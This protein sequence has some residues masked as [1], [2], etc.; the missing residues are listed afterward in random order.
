MKARVLALY[1]PQFHP[2]PENDLWWGKGFT[3]WTNVGKARRMF[4]GHYQPRVPADLGYYDLRVSETRQ[5]QADLALKHGVEGFLYWHYWFGHGKQLLEKPFNEVLSSGKPLFPFALAWANATWKGFAYGEM[6]RNVLI[7]QSYPGPGDQIM[8]FNTVLPAFKDRRYITVD[9]K[10]FFLVFQ[11]FELPDPKQFIELWQNLARTNGL[12]GIHFVAQ[13]DQVSKVDELR[14]MGFDAVNLIRM[15]HSFS[16]PKTFM[17]SS[18]L[19]MLGRI[20]GRSLNIRSYKRSLPFW[21]GAEDKREDCYPSIYPNWDHTPRS[22]K[23]G[24]ILQGSTPLL[25]AEHCHQIFKEVAHKEEEKKIVILKS[26]N[27]WAE[28]NYM[29]PDLRWGTKYLEALRETLVDNE[30]N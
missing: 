26:W 9:N 15:Y 2:I 19:K 10:P 16:N 13:T 18:M 29:E 12:P 24:I 14:S 30:C 6:G 11:P 22:G 23:R 28:G 3:E 4:P 25:F 8:H 5:Q 1:L 27:E 20:T 17:F 21:M 7:E